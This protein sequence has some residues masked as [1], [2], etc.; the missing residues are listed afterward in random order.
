MCALACG[1]MGPTCVGVG[2]LDRAQV[3]RQYHI[4]R[5]VRRGQAAQGRIGAC[6]WPKCN[7]ATCNGKNCNN[8]TGQHATGKIATRK[9]QRGNMQRKKLQHANCIRHLATRKLQVEN[10]TGQ[11]ATRKLQRENASCSMRGRGSATAAPSL[12]CGFGGTDTC[13]P[14]GL[15]L[16]HIAP[17]PVAAAVPEDRASGRAFAGWGRGEERWAARR[18]P[19]QEHSASPLRGERRSEHVH[20]SAAQGR[21]RPGYALQGRARPGYALQGRGQAGLCAAGAL[22]LFG[23]MG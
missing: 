13:S 19:V 21:V 18:S 14:C 11:H 17:R 5:T 4:R 1:L 2:G 8:A 16:N 9:M 7:G 23:R 20:V 12:A 15:G 10:A 3:H 22:A 6:R